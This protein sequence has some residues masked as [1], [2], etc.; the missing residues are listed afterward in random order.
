MALLYQSPGSITPR[1][2]DLINSARK[3]KDNAAD[4]HNFMLKWENINDAGFSIA[5]RI[6]NIKLGT[7]IESPDKLETL[8]GDGN[9]SHRG[10]AHVQYNKELEECCTELQDLLD[11]MAKLVLKM[12][13]LSSTMKGICE[14]E[15]YYHGETERETPFFNTWTTKYFYEV[16]VQLSEMYRKEMQLKQLIAQEI[17]HTSDRNLMLMQLSAWL[18]QPYVEEKA[19]LLV[20]SMLL[21]TGHRPL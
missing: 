7:R 5:N 17:A 11:K 4:W 3:L 6:V 18:Y 19:K 15:H 9:D 14:L 2:A 20:E 21:E 1:K 8:E 16:S 10:N 13:R 12:E